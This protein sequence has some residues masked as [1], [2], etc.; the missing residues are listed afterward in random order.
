MAFDERESL[1]TPPYMRTY[2]ASLVTSTVAL[3]LVA[4]SADAT[5]PASSD[6]AESNLV[7]SKNV[8]LPKGDPCREALG[9]LA[10]GFAE[11]AV[12]S[13]YLDGVK[14]TLES[15]DEYRHYAVAVD[16]KSF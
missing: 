3:A 4:C 1:A 14:V 16:G 10:L 13:D 9:S 5:G 2:L 15:E 12:G 8:T 6:S 11:G 7:A